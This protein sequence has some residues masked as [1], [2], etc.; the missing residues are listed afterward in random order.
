VSWLWVIPA[1]LALVG[2]AVLLGLARR[3]AEEVTGLRKDLG[4]FGEI[5]AAVRELRQ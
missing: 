3:A 1:A 2:G 5:V 4:R